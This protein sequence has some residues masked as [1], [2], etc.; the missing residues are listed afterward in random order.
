VLI[1]PH[2]QGTVGAAEGQ[3]EQIEKQKRRTR[4]MSRRKR[5]LR[6]RSREMTDKLTRRVVVLE[7]EAFRRAKKKK[8]E[9]F[10]AT[11]ESFGQPFERTRG[12]STADREPEDLN[13]GIEPRR[14]QRGGHARAEEVPPAAQAG[15]QAT[16][17]ESGRWRY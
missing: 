17:D 9:Q 6:A 11:R 5:K 7:R 16:A 3:Q 4:E 15:L 13:K 14:L 1:E 12:G 10:R 2:Q 8:M